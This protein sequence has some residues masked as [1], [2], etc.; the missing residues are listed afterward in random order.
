MTWFVGTHVVSSGSCGRS[1]G[2]YFT[3]DPASWT[4]AGVRPGDVITLVAR[5]AMDTDGAAPTGRYA[6]AVMRRLPF[7]DQPKGP[8][9][10]QLIDLDTTQVRTGPA[11]VTL[12]ESRPDQ[13]TAEITRVLDLP[14]GATLEAVAQTPGQLFIE[15]A[16]E[17]VRTCEWHDYGAGLCV[18]ML[19]SELLGTGPVTVTFRPKYVT[20][21]WRV[22]VNR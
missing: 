2:S 20:G 12:V 19:P 21:R 18:T 10:A 14:A 9:P 7:P 22:V 8:R 13:P 16:G 4:D 15:V 1:Y 3:P 6:V 11:V 5:V 17:P